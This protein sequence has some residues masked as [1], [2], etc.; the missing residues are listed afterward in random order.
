[1]SCNKNYFHIL[2]RGEYWAFYSNPFNPLASKF[3]LKIIN[4]AKKITTLF[5]NTMQNPC[6]LPPNEDDSYKA[7]PYLSCSI[8]DIRVVFSCLLELF[9]YRI[10]E[11]YVWK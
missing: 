6:T 11:S 10:K 7:Q 8:L 1:M 5:Q 2:L 9:I 4:M 3:F